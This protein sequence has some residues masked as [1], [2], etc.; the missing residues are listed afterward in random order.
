[1]RLVK[2]KVAYTCGLT[3]TE[4]AS[5]DTESGELFLPPRLTALMKMMEDSESAP[6]FTLDYTGYALHVRIDAS[7]AYAVSLP[8]GR[9]SRICQFADSIT[10]PTQSQR[11]QNGRLIHTLS[12]AAFVS[13]AATVHAAPSFDWGLL[14]SIVLQAGGGVLLWYVGFLCMKED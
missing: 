13:A 1:M 9:G 4:T 6:A 7:G 3:V 2:V 8:E 11:Q 10:Y 5:M 14:S 12:A